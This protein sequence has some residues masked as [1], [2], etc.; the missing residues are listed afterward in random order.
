MLNNPFCYFPRPSVVKAADDLIQRIEQSPVLRN[1]FREGKMLGVLEIEDGSFLYAFSG[2]AGGRSRIDGFVPPIYEYEPSAI[3]SSSHQQSIELQK[4][5]FEKYVVIN[6]LGQKESIYNIFSEKGIVPPGGTGDCAAPKLLQYAFLNGHTPI[7]MGEFWYGNSP[8]REVRRS[9][10][11]YPSC[12]GKCGVL[13]PWMLQGIEVEPNPLESDLLWE[14]QEPIILFEDN[15]IVVVEKPSGML[16]VPGRSSRKPL[17][18][19]LQDYCGC[20]IYSCHR[21][22]M[23]TSGVMV[24]AKNKEC[25]SHIQ[26]QFENREVG[27]SYIA[28]LGSNGGNITEGKRLKVGDKG[29][30]VLP[31]ALDYYDRPRQCIDFENG[32]QSVTQYEV[33]SHNA[34]GSIDVIM[35]PFTGRTHQLRVHAAHQS[36][37][38]MP[39]V[40]DRLYGGIPAKRLMLHADTLS[41][42][43]PV[44]YSRL[45]FSG[46]KRGF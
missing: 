8:A 1:I 37:L 9:G 17:Q 40:G 43:H 28:R 41:F 6:G 25:Q 46:R 2:L 34:D 32:K 35:T 21:L 26:Q 16:A 10:C 31:L 22:D 24:F 11:F 36:G 39:I 23:D 14:I 27:K 4:E 7:S 20:E 45:F 15:D 44:T 30:I 5:L 3:A 19:W 18:Q 29:K 33:I 42:R 12:T 13:L 38:G